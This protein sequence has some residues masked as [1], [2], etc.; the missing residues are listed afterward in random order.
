MDLASISFSDF[1]LI[2]C[3]IDSKICNE[4]NFSWYIQFLPKMGQFA[5]FAM[6]SIRTQ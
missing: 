3:S 5:N 4:F 6:L 2:T 1:F